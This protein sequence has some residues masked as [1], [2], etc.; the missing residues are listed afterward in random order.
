[1]T[2]YRKTLIFQ[3]TLPIRE[4][5]HC[6]RRKLFGFTDFNPLFPY[7]KRHR[8][9][10]SCPSPL[11]IISI[12]SSH[13]GRDY[14]R[15]KRRRRNTDFNPLFPYGKR[16]TLSVPPASTKIFQSTLPIRE[17][18]KAIALA[19]GEV[20]FQSTLPIREETRSRANIKALATIS[21]HSSHTG[22]DMR[23]SISCFRSAHFNPLFP[24]GKRQ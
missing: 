5:T 11:V 23:L 13:T 14:S 15:N 24:Y 12:H 18:T 21:I 4:E 8:K 16:H 9:I 17:E 7:G 22:R 1:M 20:L 3:S 10:P 19:N 6:D 2:E